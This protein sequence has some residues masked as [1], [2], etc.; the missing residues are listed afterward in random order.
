MKKVTFKELSAIFTIAMAFIA[1]QV[2]F[3]QRE[4]P[5]GIQKQGDVPGQGSHKGWE[6]GQHKGW[7]NMQNSV[8]NTTN[9]EQM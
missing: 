6:Q 2:V 7:G 3:A 9:N 5:P 4:V 1:T 8:G